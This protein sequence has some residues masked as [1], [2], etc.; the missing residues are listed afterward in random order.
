MGKI[1]SDNFKEFLGSFIVGWVVWAKL[2]FTDNSNLGDFALGFML[3]FLGAG[4]IALFTAICTAAAVDFYK[5]KM[6]DRLFPPNKK[7]KDK[8][9]IS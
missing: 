9:D 4:M 2:L 8:E 6:R 7:D 3:K 5:H 1:I